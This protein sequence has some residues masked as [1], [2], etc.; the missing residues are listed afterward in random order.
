MKG[1][2]FTLEQCTKC[3][4]VKEKIKDK[5]DIIIVQHPHN[6]SDWTTEHVAFAMRHGVLEDLKK[7]APVLVL[8]NG[9]KFVG[10]L[11]IMKVIQ[12]GI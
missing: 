9:T 8:Y 3:E 1:L 10:Q 2:L 5:E 4:A 7:T 12:D 6:L 11:R